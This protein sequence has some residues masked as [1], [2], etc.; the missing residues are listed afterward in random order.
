M[1]HIL[2]AGTG[3][4]GLDIGLLL[5]EKG[6]DVTW[7]SS[8]V[9]NLESVRRRVKKTIT[10][11]I[12]HL[13]E[14]Y[15]PGNANFIKTCS[16]IVSPPD[17]ILETTSE[18]LAKKQRVFREFQDLIDE[19]SIPASNSSSFLPNKIHP[20]CTGI[21]FFI[22][23][24]LTCTAELI[25]NTPE[26]ADTCEQFLYSIGIHTIRQGSENAFA[27][28]RLLLPFQNEIF[29]L[30]RS[31]M[32]IE[33]LEEVSQNPLLQFNHIKFLKIIGLTTLSKSVNNYVSRMSPDYKTTFSDITDA[34]DHSAETEK[35]PFPQRSNRP[36]NSLY[37][38]GLSDELM[39]L[40]I[41]TCWAFI[42]DNQITKQDLNT[43]LKDIFGSEKGI[44]DVTEKFG[45]KYITDSLLRNYKKTGLVYYKPVV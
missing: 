29:R 33:K 36:D 7:Y 30:I 34:L 10:R 39:F 28:N 11:I 13:S 20:A 22:P 1:N 40:F 26:E 14:S 5:L 44:Q 3:K 18:D 6:F 19:K 9:N 25:Q 32:S 42:R 4:T 45:I 23:T 12:K 21:H 41:N 24:K 17:L 27:V 15:T 16:E 37:H 38:K 2:V 31:G 8:D 35:T 43:A